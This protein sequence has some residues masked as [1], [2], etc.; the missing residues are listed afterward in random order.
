[1]NRAVKVS[2]LVL[3]ALG[4][5]VVP[6]LALQPPVITLDRVE[7]ANI[8]PFFAK[9]RV[10]FKDAND[11]GKDLNVGAMLN[12]AYIL[13]IKNPN[14]E[15]VMLD[16]LTFTTAFDGFDVNTAIA[17]E[18][19]WIAPGK[20]NEVRI[21]VTNET[22]A[23]IGSLSVG[24]QNVARV[25]EMKTTPAELVKKWWETVG[26]FAFPI[27]VTGGTALF[28]DEKGK[29]IQATFSGAWPKK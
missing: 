4:L 8:Q 28:K 3:V 20:A 7:V 22:V 10:G 24:A 29:E 5:A 27:T 2:I 13:N 25:Q 12:M 6:A 11:P 14:K 9:P 15:P 18:D 1:M 16:E 26:D 21:V 17:Y 19:S 23:T